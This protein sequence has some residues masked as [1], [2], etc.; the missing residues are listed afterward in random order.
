VLPI[1]YIGGALVDASLNHRAL[2]ELPST[3]TYSA[4]RVLM[5]ERRFRD[6]LDQGLILR[7]NRGL[8]RKADAM[9]DEDL[10]EVAARRPEATLCLRSA[11]ARH[12]LTDDIPAEID[13]A[14]PRGVKGVQTSVPTTWHYFAPR[15]FAIG[16]EL[17]HLDPT[18]DIGIYSAE[19]SIIDAYRLRHLEGPEVA[20]EAL[21]RWLRAG[22][23]PVQILKM[24][25]SFPKA[26]PALR[27]ALEVLL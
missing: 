19:R 2:A 21:R 25:R 15:T 7:L 16:R 3:F 17:L 24:A 12:E 20:N 18:T 9:G 23:Q 14:L 10:I 8:Y 27:T 5:N 26:M 13:I 4:A 1:S 11:L 6:L 22:G